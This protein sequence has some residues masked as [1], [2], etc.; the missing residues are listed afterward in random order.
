MLAFAPRTQPQLPISRS[1]NSK[2]GGL[3]KVLAPLRHHVYLV[4]SFC[5]EVGVVKRV[6]TLSGGVHRLATAFKVVEEVQ[7]E[8]Q[9]KKDE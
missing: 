3:S 7:E 5:E 9:E 2:E 6:R 1:F 4:L 8:V